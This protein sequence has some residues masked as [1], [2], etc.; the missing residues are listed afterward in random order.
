MVRATR[1]IYGLQIRWNIDNARR[2]K[3]QD[4]TDMQKGDMQRKIVALT[5]V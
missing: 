4:E 3:V 1:T 5:Y 2:L